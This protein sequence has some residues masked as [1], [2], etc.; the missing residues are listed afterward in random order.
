MREVDIMREKEK[1]LTVKEVAE[2]LGVSRNTVYSWIKEGRIKALKF[3][4]IIRIP[5][6]EIKASLSKGVDTDAKDD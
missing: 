6:K 3:K 5:E 2:M 1:M 4:R